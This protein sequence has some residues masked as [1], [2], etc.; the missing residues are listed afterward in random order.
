MSRRGMT[1]VFMVL[2]PTPEFCFLS[3]REV[4][5]MDIVDHPVYIALEAI[6]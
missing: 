5:L 4:D 2:G 1:S 6:L 3:N